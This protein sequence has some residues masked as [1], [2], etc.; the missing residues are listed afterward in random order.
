MEDIGAVE[1]HEKI[2]KIQDLQYKSLNPKLV[3]ERKASE[4][5]YSEELEF[6]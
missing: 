4:S 5:Q 3:Y 1:E 6:H 2:K